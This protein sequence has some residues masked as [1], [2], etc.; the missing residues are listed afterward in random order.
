VTDP[1][2]LC[3]VG[4]PKTGKTTYLAALWSYLRSD[5]P[6]DQYRITELP[7]DTSYLDAISYAW[8]A[9]ETMPR[10]SPEVSDHIEF[11][12]EV[13]DRP[14]LQVVLP[15]LP[16][17]VFLNAVR[18]PVIGE[19]P[20]TAVRDSDLLLLFVNSKSAW[21]FEPL[22]DHP[23][24]PNGEGA[25]PPP[26]ANEWNDD[27][28][29]GA[30]RATEGNNP[31]ADGY[32]EHETEGGPTAPRFKEFDIGALDTDTLNYELI[33]RLEHFLGDAGFPPLLIVVSAWDVFAN[34]SGAGDEVYTPD[35]WLREH[36]PM[37]WQRVEEL[38]RTITVGVVGVSAQGAD[39]QDK[40]EIVEAE[41]RLRA[42]GSDPD[43]AKTD[44]VGPLLWYHALPAPDA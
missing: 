11:T 2:R 40:P 43:G 15:D 31:V 29:P 25:E 17:E 22:G 32:E 13:P 38:R 34:P 4:L 33:E 27:P 18:R 21:M 6:D 9:G 28:A 41:A 10:S 30:D 26:P 14:P 20:G 19:G 16:G 23:A 12:I 35:D 1:F 8:A 37:L 42:W 36:Q 3:L 24:D 39:Y 5:L 44:I 7:E